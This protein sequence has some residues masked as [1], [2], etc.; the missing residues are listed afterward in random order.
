MTPT[1]L[2]SLACDVSRHVQRGL[3]I[4]DIGRILTV[5]R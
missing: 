1:V 2:P 5:R 4:S 3:E